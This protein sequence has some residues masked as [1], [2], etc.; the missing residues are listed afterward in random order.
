LTMRE[1]EVARKIAEGLTN[2]ELAKELG[3]SPK[4]ASAHVEHILA[5][6]DV[7]RRAEI[8]AWVATLQAAAVPPRNDAPLAS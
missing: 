6:L 2:A 5:K 7:N 1:L 3:I 8:A 4:T